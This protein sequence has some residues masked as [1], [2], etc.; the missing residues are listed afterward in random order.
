MLIAEVRAW[1][2]V[3]LSVGRLAVLNQ[4]GMGF[5]LRV[6]EA[7]LGSRVGGGDAG[8]LGTGARY[9]EDDRAAPCVGN[10]LGRKVRWVLALLV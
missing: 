7:G 10:T 3:S 1:E 5:D 2:E 6:A 9:L 8:V 4:Q